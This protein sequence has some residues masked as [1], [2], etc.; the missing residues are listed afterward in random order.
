MAVC[1][2]LALGGKHHAFETSHR[3]EGNPLLSIVLNF[4]HTTHCMQ[5]VSLILVLG[6]KTFAEKVLR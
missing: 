5:L 3:Q 4:Y 2:V 6:P 1:F